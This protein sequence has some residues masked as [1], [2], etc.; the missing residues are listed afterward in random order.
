M[1][2]KIPRGTWNSCSPRYFNFY[3]VRLFLSANHAQPAV[4]GLVRPDFR[5]ASVLQRFLYLRQGINSHALDDVRPLFVPGTFPVGFIAD[6]EGSTAAQ[7]PVY[8]PESSP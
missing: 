6:E 2:I 3:F 4:T 1:R 7:Y 8:L 5:E